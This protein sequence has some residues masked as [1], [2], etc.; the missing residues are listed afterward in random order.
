MG[1]DDENFQPIKDGSHWCT[2]TK[3]SPHLIQFLV[4]YLYSISIKYLLLLLYVL[5]D[6]V[7]QRDVLMG[8]QAEF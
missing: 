8:A 2:E 1:R 6:M 4:I 7:Q 5:F 3:N